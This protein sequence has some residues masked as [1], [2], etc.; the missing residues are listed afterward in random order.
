MRH[1]RT[2]KLG[3]VGRQLSVAGEPECSLP[4]KTKACEK[5]G[6]IL[7]WRLVKGGPYIPLR[8]AAAWNF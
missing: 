4:R 6:S 7:P 8:Q 2:A 1:K 3:H 5:L